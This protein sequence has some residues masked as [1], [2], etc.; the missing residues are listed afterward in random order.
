[1]LP[2][3]LLICA[4]VVVAAAVVALVVVAVVV[5]MCFH[6]CSKQIDAPD[7]IDARCRCC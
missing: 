6:T 2:T 5:L 1:M 4:F 3:A 7:A